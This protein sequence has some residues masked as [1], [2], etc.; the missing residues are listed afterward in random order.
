MYAFVHNDVAY[1]PDGQITD[2]EGTP[3]EAKDAEAFNRELEAQE[4]EHIKSAPDKLVLYIGHKPVPNDPKHECYCVQT[5]LGTFLGWAWLGLRSTMG[6]QGHYRGGSYR[7]PV[8]VR[9][10]STLYHGWY[11]ESSGDYCR[12]K[13]AKRQDDKYAATVWNA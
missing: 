11:M 1:G 12:L 13:K 10:F 4:L 7:R 3:L 9:I 8:T 2:V 6:F 5:W